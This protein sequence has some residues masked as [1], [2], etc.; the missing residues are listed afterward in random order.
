MRKINISPDRLEYLK[1]SI[2]IALEDFMDETHEFKISI[3][4]KQIKLT[5]KGFDNIININFYA[6]KI[7]WFKRFIEYKSPE[8]NKVFII[9]GEIIHKAVLDDR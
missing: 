7:E 2:G 6:S 1:F 3:T 5:L 8:K 4:D 9:V